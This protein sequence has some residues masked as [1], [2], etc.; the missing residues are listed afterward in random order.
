MKILVKSFKPYFKKDHS[1]EISELTSTIDTAEGSARLAGENQG[2]V[3]PG[4]EDKHS[5]LRHEHMPHTRK[6][7]NNSWMV[8]SFMRHLQQ[9]SLSHAI[10]DA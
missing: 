7:R 4:A 9:L 1:S 2:P 10:F 8:K 6:A 3:S 5:Q